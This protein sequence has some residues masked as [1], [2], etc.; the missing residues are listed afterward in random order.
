MKNIK[1]LIGLLAM[2]AFLGSCGSIVRY[3]SVKDIPPSFFE[4]NRGEGERL[5]YITVE[6]AAN[7]EYDG[8][9]IAHL[10]IVTNEAAIQSLTAP[11]TI[12]SNP[13]L[14][15]L[16]QPNPSVQNS[17][18]ISEKGLAVFSLPMSHEN[19]GFSFYCSVPTAKAQLATGVTKVTDEIYSSG[20]VMYKIAPEAGDSDV[21]IRVILSPTGN[22]P[23]HVLSSASSSNITQMIS[24]C[25]SYGIPNSEGTGTPGFIA[26]PAR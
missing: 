6:M 13:I 8:S 14:G 25:Y 19:I 2:S 24:N 1:L 20:K 16:R 12:S 4:E 23:I 9:N 10:F 21:A 3:V 26:A 17:V 5:V 18:Y 22:E 7:I 11:Y 15:T